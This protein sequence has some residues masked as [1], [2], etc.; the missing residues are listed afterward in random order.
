MLLPVVRAGIAT[1][2]SGLATRVLGSGW[3]ALMALVGP[4]D[5]AVPPWKP[6]QHVEIVVAT[7][8]GSGSDSTPVNVQGSPFYSSSSKSRS[9]TPAWA[10]VLAVIA[11]LVAA[12]GA[13]AAG[14]ALMKK[15]HESAAAVA[16]SPQL[17]IYDTSKPSTFAPSSPTKAV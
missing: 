14:V 6:D 3:L 1:G 5:A 17:P 8:P 2:A 13:G 9:S 7:S 16:S 10:I 11:T 4:C 12:A 15:R